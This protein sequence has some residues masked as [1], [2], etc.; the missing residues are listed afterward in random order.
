[1]L[2]KFFR[3]AILVLPI[4]LLLIPAQMAFA[5]IMDFKQIKINL[6]D[7]K[8]SEA[9]ASW[10]ENLNI[11][12]KGLGHDSEN[13][14]TVEGW[15]ETKPIAVGYSW[16]VPYAI[17]VNVTVIP[18]PQEIKLAN[19]QGYT[20]HIGAAYIRYSP[21]KKN[22]SSWQAL[23]P[24]TVPTERAFMGL[25]Q[26]PAAVRNDYNDLLMDYA[27]RD[28]VPWKSD[29]E[30]AVKWI[31]EKDPTYFKQKQ[32]FIGYIS[33][34]FEAPFVTG[35]RLLSFSADI[36]YGMS[37]L[38]APPSQDIPA[39]EARQTMPWRFKAE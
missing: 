23:I 20:P 18:G 28:D 19:G 32:P 2:N 25:V 12:D 35:H 29:E 1:M 16:R 7:T 9:Q 24:G 17:R 15:I 37:G 36:S 30:A 8:E 34:L 27:R 22:W 14:T 38:H 26:V 11:T 6:T 31:L 4:A 3:T 21:D 33:F 13:G 5:S 39:Y 10:S